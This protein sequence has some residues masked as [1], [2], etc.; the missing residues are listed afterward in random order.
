LG[1]RELD[2]PLRDLVKRLNARERFSIQ[3]FIRKPLLEREFKL[4][5]LFL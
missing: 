5:F 2:T 3:I 1:E 4:F